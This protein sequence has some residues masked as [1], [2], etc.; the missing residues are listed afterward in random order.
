MQD[1]IQKAIK[2]IDQ[3]GIV[4]FPTDTAFGIGCRI[5]DEEAIKKLFAIRKRSE[6]HAMPV[7]VD[8]VKMA[9]DYLLPLPG[10]VRHLID[11][12]WPGALTIVFSCR[13][14]KVPLLVRGGRQN[15]GVR[16]PNHPIPLGI[17]G[18]VGVPMIGSSANFHGEKTPY[19]FED[20][21]KELVKLV[22]FVVPG[23]CMS[24]TASTVLDCS[25]TPWKVLRQG[26]VKIKEQK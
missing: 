25:V 4:I 14:E 22:D 18:A 10:D 6:I 16:M 9:E 12:H 2:I 1:D 21:D 19:R 13:T 20:L 26:A 15:L 5:D 11:G 8:S 3:G 7:L 23:E 24:D 17:I